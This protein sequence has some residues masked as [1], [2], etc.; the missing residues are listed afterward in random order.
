MTSTRSSICNS[1]LRYVPGTK[2]TINKE[3]GLGTQDTTFLLT[4]GRSRIDAKPNSR[5]RSPA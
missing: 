1:V 3:R 4:T 2:D 5:T